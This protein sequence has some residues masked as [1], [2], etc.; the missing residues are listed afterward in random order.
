[1]PLVPPRSRQAPLQ[2]CAFV[3][4]AVSVTPQATQTL[5]VQVEP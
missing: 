1:M 4:Q 5:P 3:V 2:H